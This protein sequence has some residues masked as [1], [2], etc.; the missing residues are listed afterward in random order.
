MKGILKN[1]EPTIFT[2]WKANANEDWTPTFN[3]L[4][5]PEKAAVRRSLLKEQGFICAYCCSEI[6]DDVKTTVIEHFI[7]QSDAEKGV[8][9]ALNY[10]NLFASCDGTKL[11][12]KAKKAIYC[13]DESKKDQFRNPENPNIILI[14]P[15]EKDKNAF[16]CEQAFGY[17]VAGGVF[18]METPFKEDALY[19]LKV[20]N[21]DN[22][23]LKRQRKEVC[24]FLLDENGNV[25]D[26]TEAEVEKIRA[27]Y[28]QKV[29]DKFQPFC[30]TVL[31]FLK[32][33][34]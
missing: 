27:Y 3:K 32:S 17:T 18:A 22:S 14:K 19:S 24:S 13:C 26:L 2:A 28:A 23:L 25:L 34:F 8:E 21:L 15:T 1:S 7:P 10:E 33:Y 12:N 31:Y 11:D 4:Q 6:K 30:Q 16:I 9:N 20:L 5:N 29:D